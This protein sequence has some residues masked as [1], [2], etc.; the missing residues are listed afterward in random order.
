MS[1]PFIHHDLFLIQNQVQS[2]TCKVHFYIDSCISIKKRFAKCDGQL[3][4]INT[5][6]EIRDSSNSENHSQLSSP[7]AIMSHCS[8]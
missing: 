5:R 2:T 3:N 7:E 4:W 6:G 1:N 8:V